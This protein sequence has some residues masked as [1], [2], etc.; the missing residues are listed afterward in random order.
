MV[1]AFTIRKVGELSPLE[2]FFK[3]WVNLHAILANVEVAVEEE[4]EGE[5][6]AASHNQIQKEMRKS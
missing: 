1:D 2:Q 5:D 3:Q 4:L 6:S